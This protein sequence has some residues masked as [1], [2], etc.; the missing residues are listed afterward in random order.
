MTRFLRA[1]LSFV[2]IIVVFMGLYVGVISAAYW[3][4]YL[5]FFLFR[6]GHPL[7]G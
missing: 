6:K 5:F 3:M 4:S 2:I 7:C 1:L